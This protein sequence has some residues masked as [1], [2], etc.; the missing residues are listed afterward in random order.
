MIKPYFEELIKKIEMEREKETAPIKA[1]L[2]RDKIAPFNAQVDADQ[3]KAL[4]EL[5]RTLNAEIGMMREKYAR[6]K[7]EIVEISEKQKKANEDAV[8]STELNVYTA[9]YDKQIDK[10][11]AQMAEIEE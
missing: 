7:Q 4:A 8:L 6:K 2:M 9:K 11:K 5:D 1:S 3:A 10:L